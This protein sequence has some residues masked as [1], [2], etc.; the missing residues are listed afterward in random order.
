V[1]V[2]EECKPAVKDLFG[3][4]PVCAKDLCT[5]GDPNACKY[6]KCSEVAPYQCVMVPGQLTPECDISQN[7]TDPTAPNAKCGRYACNAIGKCAVMKGEGARYNMCDSVDAEGYCLHFACNDENMCVLERNTGCNQKD[8]CFLGTNLCCREELINKELKD[9]IG[10]RAG[11]IKSDEPFHTCS[12]S[13]WTN[14][15]GDDIFGYSK[16]INITGCKGEIEISAEGCYYRFYNSI[17]GGDNWYTNGSIGLGGQF[18]TTIIGTTYPDALRTGWQVRSV[19]NSYQFNFINRNR[20]VNAGV[21][22]ST[23]QK[24]NRG[25]NNW[26]RYY[27]ISENMGDE[28]TLPWLNPPPSNDPFPNGFQGGYIKITD[29]KFTPDPIEYN[30]INT[31]EGYCPEPTT[32]CENQS[33]GAGQQ[34]KH[35]LNRKYYTCEN[36]KCV[37]HLELL[38]DCGTSSE[39]KSCVDGDVSRVTINNTCVEPGPTECGQEPR[40]QNTVRG[41]FKVK[42]CGCSFKMGPGAYTCCGESQTE[43]KVECD[44]DAECELECETKQVAGDKIC[45]NFE[46]TTCGSDG[47]DLDCIPSS[48]YSKP[49]MDCGPPQ[50]VVKEYCSGKVQC[51][52]TATYPGECFV[53]LPGGVPSCRAPSV[54]IVCNGPCKDNGDGGDKDDGDRNPGPNPNPGPGPNPPDDDDDDDNGDDPN[55]P[56]DPDDPDDETHTACTVED[57]KCV[58]VQGEGDNECD[59]DNDCEDDDDESHTACTVEDQK[60][61]EVQGEGEDECESRD[62]CDDPD[63]KKLRCNPYN[64]CVLRTDEEG[65]AFCSDSIDCLDLQT[66]CNENQQC[67][68]DGG[69][70]KC[71]NPEDCPNFFACNNYDQCVSGGP[72]KSCSAEGDCTSSSTARCTID[73]TQ[74]SI[75]GERMACDN[76]T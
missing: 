44:D 60:C 66:S 21:G 2:S 75:Q 22:Y 36:K 65:G 45:Q 56:D 30:C 3:E 52:L 38:Q 48:E 26:F 67:E 33:G 55:D 8:E 24:T 58:E 42:G 47:G 6:A 20:I 7:P 35:H 54:D 25:N 39:I 5:L 15:C 57:Q 43:C 46:C 23:N 17:H 73:G 62:D 50:E 27:A 9:L 68:Q 74:C 32:Y 4:F 29:A 14:T 13:N 61:V 41:P 19:T 49:T 11:T 12:T 1:P 18:P 34:E 40:C 59:D 10:K 72:G 76:I 63:E 37:E 51:T 71:I 53:L 28:N 64:Q 69:G 31:P 70:I 16:P